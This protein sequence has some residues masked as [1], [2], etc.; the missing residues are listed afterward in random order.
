MSKMALLTV[1]PVEFMTA[2]MADVP[3]AHDDLDVGVL[4]VHDILED[5]NFHEVIVD[6]DVLYRFKDYS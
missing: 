3:C 1:M 5:C 6:Y 2:M 4:Y